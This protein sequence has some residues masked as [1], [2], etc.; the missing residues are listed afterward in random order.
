VNV[1]VLTPAA[2]RSR[3]G[4]RITA[5]RWAKILRS[6][7]H[8]V[9]IAEQHD[10]KCSSVLIALHAWKSA[11]DIRSFRK[12]CPGR[13]IILALSG[14]DLYRD[15]DH[16]AS[17]R[18]SLVIA[19]RIV[20]L[21]SDAVNHLPAHI[22]PKCR[23]IFQ[24]ARPLV[25]DKTAP[26]QN[27]FD[28]AVIG[29]LRPVK[30]PFRAAL[31]ARKLPARSTIRVLHLGQA[32]SDA[33]QQRA[34]REAARNQRYQWLGKKTQTQAMRILARCRLLVVT[35][36]M[37]GGAN[38]VSEALAVGVPV[39]SSRISGSVGI[40]GQDYPGFFSVGDTQA[41]ADLL[42]KC[43]DDRE[44]YLELKRCA[45]KLRPLVD[46]ARERTAWRRLIAELR[47]DER[48]VIL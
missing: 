45:R 37:E 40:L 26:D 30:D 43:E 36:K 14:T 3:R 31:A 23:V 12:A 47:Q 22:R 24:S 38:V 48:D 13:P 44:F 18:R 41:L 7:G 5:E 17:A 20:V 10:G 42:Q 39:V 1:L 34:D 28:V 9:K 16:R 2:P 27:H 8:R 32:L 4:N 46:P 19:D 21:Q 25:G 35:S 29:H 33:M 15:L 6:L 11:A